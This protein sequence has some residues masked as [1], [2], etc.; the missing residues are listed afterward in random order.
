MYAGMKSL[1]CT[2]PSCAATVEGALGK[3]PLLVGAAAHGALHFLQQLQC[4]PWNR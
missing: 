3:N 2:P 1:R 4:P